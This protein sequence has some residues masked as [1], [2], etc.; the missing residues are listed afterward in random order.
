[1]KVT[2]PYLTD[3]VFKERAKW[4][5]ETLRNEDKH[6]VCLVFGLVEGVSLFSMFA[7][8]RSFQANGYNLIA[9]TVKGTKQSAIDEAYCTLSTSLQALNTY[10]VS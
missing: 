8:L 9:T 1:M 5:G 3:P 4:L 2:Y 10:T 6:L 7:L